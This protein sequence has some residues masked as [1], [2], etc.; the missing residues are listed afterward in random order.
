MTPKELVGMCEGTKD[1]SDLTSNATACNKLHNSLQRFLYVVALRFGCHQRTERSFSIKGRQMPVC[2]R[3]L[4]ILT[5]PFVAP[6]YLFYPDERIAI[7][8]MGIFVLDSVTQVLGLRESNNWV[9]LLTGATC[10]ASVLFL[11]MNGV[12]RWL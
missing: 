3:C 2:A 8:F 10:S 12:K 9:R 7:G 6:L 5:G 11:F 1:K 4:G